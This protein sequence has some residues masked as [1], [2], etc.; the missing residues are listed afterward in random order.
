MSYK[1]Y[2]QLGVKDD[3]YKVHILQTKEEKEQ[4]IMTNYVVCVD[5]FAEWCAPCKKIEPLY[6]KLS[7]ELQEKNL[8][9][10]YKEDIDSNL[11]QNLK[12]VPT[13][14]IY[15]GRLLYKKVEG[16]NLEEVRNILLECIA[17][18]RKNLEDSRTGPKNHNA[19]NAIRQERPIPPE[20][21][22]NLNTPQIE[23][24]KIFIPHNTKSSGY[25]KLY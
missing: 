23:T 13:F 18:G 3:A 15:K 9:V 10:F 20:D 21:L 7:M 16:A 4:A 8:C 12:S 22:S 2:S 25:S 24:S 1:S 5:V 17:E 19:P 11:T 6:Q 14:L